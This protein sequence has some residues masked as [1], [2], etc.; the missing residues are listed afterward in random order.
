MSK[1]ENSPTA[2]VR[3]LLPLRTTALVVNVR[4]FANKGVIVHIKDG[5]TLDDVINHSAALFRVIQKSRDK[6][7]NEGD[8]VE[9]RWP[10]QIAFTQVD[11]VDGDSVFLPQADNLSSQGTQHDPVGKRDVARGHDKRSIQLLA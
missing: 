8:M 5:H 6:A 11:C 2:A 4:K 9:L 10:D 1:S 7:L 3:E